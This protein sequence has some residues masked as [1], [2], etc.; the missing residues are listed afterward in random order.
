MIFLYI[1]LFL[2]PFR[3]PKDL[4]ISYFSVLGKF[5]L[6]FGKNC[7]VSAIL[8]LSFFKN[9]SVFQKIPFVFIE[10]D[11]ILGFLGEFSNFW[12]KYGLKSVKWSLFYQNFSQKPLNLVHLK[13]STKT[14]KSKNFV[15]LSFFTFAQFLAKSALSFRKIFVK[16]SLQW[17][18]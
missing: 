17:Y 10:I 18:A 7:S 2:T 8:E 15:F 5:L 11:E 16:K 9:F 14:L 6:S 3:I 4:K 1:R 13:V 12:P